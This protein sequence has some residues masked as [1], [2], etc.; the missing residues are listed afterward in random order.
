MANTTVTTGK[1]VNVTGLDADW[2]WSTDLPAH[3]QDKPLAS[4]EYSPH[5]ANDVF[6]LR[7]GSVTGAKCFHV[8]C[9]GD[10]D[11]RVRYYTRDEA[12]SPAFES[13][14]LTIGGAN[15]L[16]ILTFHQ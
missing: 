5:G 4:V 8:K 1:I 9:T 14:D 13:S 10:T 15:A 11:Q 12:V 7:N 3:L 2:I 16:L 6:V